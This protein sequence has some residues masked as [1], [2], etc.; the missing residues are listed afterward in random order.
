MD[1]PCE[2][3]WSK[4]IKQ[5]GTGVKVSQPFYQDRGHQ[6]C[7]MRTPRVPLQDLFLRDSKIPPLQVSFDSQTS[8]LKARY[9]YGGNRSPGFFERFLGLLSLFDEIAFMLSVEPRTGVVCQSDDFIRQDG[10]LV[11]RGKHSASFAW[12]AAFQCSFPL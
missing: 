8:I 7:G 2:Q 12:K 5:M 4:G 11:L 10:A 1:L 9:D 6:V 3:I